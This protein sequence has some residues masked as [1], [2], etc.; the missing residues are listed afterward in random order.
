MPKNLVGYQYAKQKK[1][2]WLT[3][4]NL[5]SIKENNLLLKITEQ[6]SYIEKFVK[7][8]TQAELLKKAKK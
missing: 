4:E 2:K 3:K 5:N 7:L 8:K 6:Q 1:I